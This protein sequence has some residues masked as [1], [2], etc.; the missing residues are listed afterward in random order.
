MKRVFHLFI[1][2]AMLGCSY[3][4]LSAQRQM[5]DDDR[6]AWSQRMRDLKHNFL[7]KELGLTR[8]QQ[9]EFFPLYDSMEDEL[10]AMTAQ[11]RE[12][13]S[14]I[15]SGD[16]S[17]SDLEYSSAAKTLFEQ[18]GKE[19][20]L[21]LTYFEKFEKILTPRQLFLLKGAERDFMGQV[22]RRHGRMRGD[23]FNGQPDNHRHRKP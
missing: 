2:L 7:I 10:N 6:R 15:S 8:E 13:E 9:N 14:K 1:L 23:S 11:I 19:Y 21:E 22:V 12:F 5:T 4:Q 16:K 18:K 3:M 20:E 17:V